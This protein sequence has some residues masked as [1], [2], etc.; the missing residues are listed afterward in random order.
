MPKLTE[1]RLPSYR[2]HKQ[3]GQAI[4]TLS[5]RDHLLGPYGS[6]ASRAEYQRLTSEWQ[7]SGRQPLA[8]AHEITV[9]EVLAAFWRHAKL[10]YRDPD[11]QPTGEADNYAEALSPVRALYSRT[12]AIK[13]G[14]L[15]LTA[16]RAEM[17]RRGWARTR[18]NR[19]ISRV[20]HV[21]T[22]A[23]SKEMIPGAVSHALA[24]VKGL[25]VGRSDAKEAPPVKAVAEAHVR[26]I[27]S[28]VS[29][30]IKALIELQ[31][32]TGA[33]PGEVLTIR[34]R[35]LDTTGNLWVYRPATHKTSHH[36]HAREIYL[37]P[38]A[39]AIIEPLLTLDPSEYLFSPAKAEADRRAALHSARATPLNCGNSPGT[40]RT[41]QP[42]RP[43]GERYDIA[44]YRRAIA[45]ACD[46][47]FPPPPPLVKLEHETQAAYLARLKP[48]ELKALKAWRR[49]Q[50][51]HPHQL[52]H[53]AGTALRKEFGLEA[54]QV[55]LGH[56]TLTVT[57][58]Y[59]ERNVAAAQTIMA[60]VG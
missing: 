40:N 32:L 7:A 45:R 9:A 19:Q 33:R 57:Q 12:E 48:A 1:D 17:I 53:T 38:R 29:P 22:W 47:A 3:S 11:G 36:G 5:G 26:A 37:G 13:F 46:T 21:F 59:A 34:G 52:R 30:P 25:R 42:K 31:L 18:I 35:D 2:R 15:A 44:S 28:Y 6:A 55:I 51:F 14:P 41:A 49:A 24:S 8:L 54:A 39:R 58:V 56:K 43:P 10:Y 50:R 4:V 20:K 23:V 16:V 27:L 60:K